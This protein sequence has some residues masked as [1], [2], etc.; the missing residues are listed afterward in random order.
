MGKTCSVCDAVI[1]KQETIPALGHTE[2]I[3]SATE[4]TCLYTGLTEGKVCSTCNTELKAQEIIPALGHNDAN[5][6]RF[7]DNCNE[8][9]TPC[10]HTNTTFEGVIQATCTTGGHT[11]KT[12]CVDCKVV[13]D[14]G[15]TILAKGH[16]FGEWTEV[17]APTCTTKGSETRNC[18]NCT[19]SETREVAALN[20]SNT[21]VEDAITPT[22][23]DDGHTGKTICAD[24]KITLDEGE[25]IPANGHTDINND[26][27]CD[28]CKEKLKVTEETTPENPETP[29]TPNDE[30][31]TCEKVGGFKAFW[32]AIVNFFRRLFGQ[33]EICTCGEIL[34][35][36]K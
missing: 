3:L 36:K 7:C 1:Q 12:I 14:D 31:H 10:P 17:T 21:T 35:K 27:I 6:D 9:L 16:S 2:V 22:C 20:H 23:T 18:K 33:P 28:T 13:I 8:E 25:T 5:N 11:G 29:E 19:H 24:C 4:A 15:R 26:D 30:E 34:E 32:N